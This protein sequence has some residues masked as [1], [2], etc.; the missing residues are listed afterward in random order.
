MCFLYLPGILPISIVVRCRI[1]HQIS[2]FLYFFFKESP[3]F[4]WFV[5]W[6]NKIQNKTDDSQAPFQAVLLDN[7][8]NVVSKGESVA[9]ENASLDVSK[10]PGGYYFLQV[11]KGTKLVKTT[12]VVQH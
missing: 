3:A 2:S 8:G 4:S 10:V 12:V 1:Y 7:L 9:G 11:K 5:L 6:I